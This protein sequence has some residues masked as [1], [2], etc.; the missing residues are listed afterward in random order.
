MRRLKWQCNPPEVENAVRRRARE[1]AEERRPRE[2][3]E[4]GGVVRIASRALGY[5]TAKSALVT[6]NMNRYAARV[7][8]APVLVVEEVPVRVAVAEV[9]SG[10]PIPRDRKEE[11]SQCHDEVSQCHDEV[12]S[13]WSG[14]GWR[15]GFDHQGRRVCL[16]TRLQMRRQVQKAAEA[17]KTCS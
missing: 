13:H 1:M 3:Q 8:E 16:P 17:H 9:P 10:P 4:P 15:Q 6:G 7:E 14:R 12:M 2:D 11:V 5:P